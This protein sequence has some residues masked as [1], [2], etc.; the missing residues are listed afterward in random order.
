MSSII[1]FFHNKP[2]RIKD[3]RVI[4]KS[5]W[6]VILSSL[7]ITCL[8]IF[9]FYISNPKFVNSSVFF[10]NLS[11]FFDFSDKH[12]G[13][14]TITIAQTLG[15]S[16]R[17]LLNTLIYSVLGTVLGIIVSIPLALLSSKN[18]VKKWYIYTPFRFV[19]SI[20][21]AIPPL[22]IAFIMFQMFSPTLTATFAIGVFVA[23][24]MTKWLFEELDTLDMETF[25]ALQAFGNSR[26]R[27]LRQSVLPFLMKKALS[28]G[29]YAFEIVIRF[30]TILGVINISTIGMLLSDRYSDVGMWG[31]M[32][33][34]LL[35]LIVTIVLI[36]IFSKIFIKYIIEKTFNKVSINKNDS[37]KVAIDHI[38]KSAPK[39]W[40]VKL[41]FGLLFIMVLIYSI[42]QIKWAMA[43]PERLGNFKS[44]VGDLFQP[45]WS[46]FKIVGTLNP[47]NAAFNALLIA[48]LAAIM[49]T[50]FGIVFGSLA[51]KNILGPYFS[52]VFKIL[53]IT[54]RS[55]PAFV[56]AII[57]IF[58]I[59]PDNNFMFGGVLALG[60]HSIGMLGKLTYEK[61]ESLD[62]GPAESLKVMGST[63]LQVTRWA[64][65]KEAMPQ[66][67]SNALYRVEI[68]LKSTVQI[69]TIGM[70]IF[71]YSVATYAADPA[72]YSQLSSFII[73][74]I[75]MILIL[76]Q[77]S[78]LG[79][80]VLMTGRIFPNR[81]IIYK[82]LRRTN[83]KKSLMNCMAFNL[84]FS[85]K[86]NWVDYNNLVSK[87]LVKIGNGKD[88]L[89]NAKEQFASEYKKEQ[90]KAEKKFEIIN[91]K[92]KKMLNNISQESD[93][94]KN[95]QK[96]IYKFLAAKE[97]IV[98][99]SAL[100]HIYE[101]YSI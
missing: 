11:K 9:L 44:L 82:F 33:I 80:K 31:H 4:K 53:I 10:H 1:D 25:N 37:K 63:K 94:Y 52:W 100:K 96:K 67:L 88:K 79:R 30:A 8:V 58:I 54:I 3:Q 72:Y 29:L 69:G 78:S 99:E 27:A 85:E 28:Y 35:V 59:S 64:L 42:I 20:M 34:V 92:D 23:T 89:Q 71:G 98:Q 75:V 15:D 16:L 70:S 32:T 5:A 91:A 84:K 57:F 43:T 95:I 86:K 39:F 12:I 2:I 97:K 62:S 50:F 36:E 83:K 45:D 24:I 66:I 40:I 61:I 56:Y 65:I 74:I 48:A 14:Q 38:Y 19:M 60:I 13:L 47:I 51:S 6:P 55:I 7:L 73:V 76:E 26:F 101:K 93:S 87:K 22:V 21:R 81:N 41:G 77:I 46:L 90:V 18:I 68:N 49:G 17:L